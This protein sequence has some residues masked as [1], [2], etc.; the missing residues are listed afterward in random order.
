MSPSPLRA[1]RDL[2]YQGFCQ[3][4]CARNADGNAVLSND[5]TAISWCILGACVK[6][7]VYY[8]EVVCPRFYKTGHTM[9]TYNDSHTKEEVLAFLDLLIA[10]DKQ[11]SDEP[12]PWIQDK[13]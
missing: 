7:G 3:G 10:E 12:F 6:A 1:I 9:A 2:L 13:P 11:V 5:P 4:C 8:P